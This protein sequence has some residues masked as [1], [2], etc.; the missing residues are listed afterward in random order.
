MDG[1]A[2]ADGFLP[3]APSAAAAAFRVV[4]H[5]RWHG[6]ALRDTSRIRLFVG[7]L[8]GG[9]NADRR[10]A[11][12]ETWGKDKRLHRCGPLCVPSQWSLLQQEARAADDSWLC[13][14]VVTQ[15]LLR[16][17]HWKYCSTKQALT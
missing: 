7:V 17:C 11:I 10:A 3:E 9:A 2:E 12:R 8:T 15:L 6:E 14:V 5:I 16:P 13:Q 4:S 1:V